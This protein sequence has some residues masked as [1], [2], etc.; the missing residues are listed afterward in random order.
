MI[1]LVP[2]ETV[3]SWE[4]KALLA[5]LRFNETMLVGIVTLRL[6]STE[7]EKSRLSA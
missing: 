1:L 7:T 4:E 2:T 3:R 6:G 5:G